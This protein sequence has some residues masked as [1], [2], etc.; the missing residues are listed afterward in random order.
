MQLSKHGQV[1]NTVSLSKDIFSASNFFMHSFNMFV[2][3]LQNVTKIQFV[4]KYFF[5]IKLLYAHLQCVCNISAVF[6]RSNESSRRSWFHKV[7][8]ISHN[9]NNVRHNF[10]NTD[11]SA[12]IFL[13]K[14]HCLM[15]KMWCKFEWNQTKAIEKSM[16]KRLKCWQNRRMTDMLKTVYPTKTTFCGEYNY[17]NVKIRCLK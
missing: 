4:K 15:V 1:K 13:S 14:M 16:S 12:P 10:C 6:K 9:I 8:T 3:Y 11:P 7:C 17:H 5:S 2:T